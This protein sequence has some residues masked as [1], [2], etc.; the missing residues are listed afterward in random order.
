MV[1][2]RAR[3]LGRLGDIEFVPLLTERTAPRGAGVAVGDTAAMV[4]AVAGS[5]GLHIAGKSSPQRAGE[6]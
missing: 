5:A 6:G 3:G 4:G 1:R 2:S